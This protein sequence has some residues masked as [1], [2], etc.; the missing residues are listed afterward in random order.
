MFDEDSSA[1][2]NA[3]ITVYDSLLGKEVKLITD[4]NGLVQYSFKVPDETLNG[5]YS[6]L[7][8]GDK[9]GYYKSNSVLKTVDVN[10]INSVYET[11]ESATISVYPQPVS[12]YLKIDLS[13]VTTNNLSDISLY[14]INSE[15]VLT[16]ED[17]GSSSETILDIRYLPSGQYLL[18]L[19]LNN[20][21]ITKS[22][23]VIR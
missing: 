21:L 5:K 18:I 15:K 13:N 2:P 9:T 11:A 20:K 22:V 8:N 12:D 1:V 16:V 6:F 4:A 10:H 23:T 17:F 14:N 7:F 3:N 19:R